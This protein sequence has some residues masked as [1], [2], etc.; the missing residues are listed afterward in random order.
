MGKSESHLRQQEGTAS[1]YAVLG[2]VSGAD[3]AYLIACKSLFSAVP[4]I[5]IEQLLLN[6]REV[7]FSQVTSAL[8]FW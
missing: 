6:Y 1:I 4:K 3:P 5:G 7:L 2:L 8:R